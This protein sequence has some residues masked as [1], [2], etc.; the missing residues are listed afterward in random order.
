MATV[1]YALLKPCRGM[2]M[3]RAIQSMALSTTAE[4]MP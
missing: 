4:P 1:T 3:T 2:E